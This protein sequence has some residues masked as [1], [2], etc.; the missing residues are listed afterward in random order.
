MLHD[1]EA[2]ASA[3]MA[4]ELST[5]FGEIVPGRD[6]RQREPILVMNLK[7]RSAIDQQLNHG[8]IVSRDGPIDR[9]D[10]V[11]INRFDIRAVIKQETRAVKPSSLDRVPQWCPT[12]ASTDI[13]ERSSIDKHFK[14]FHAFRSNSR[15]DRRPAELIEAVDL[16]TAVEKQLHHSIRT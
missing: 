4:R 14:T 3:S 5:Y 6:V 16:G 10:F 1:D 12:P 13:N 7:I 2:I 15:V 9:G 11:I 8:Q